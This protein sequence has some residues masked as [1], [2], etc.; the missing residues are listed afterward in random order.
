MAEI[1]TGDTKNGLG[2]AIL[3]SQKSDPTNMTLIFAYSLIAII[4]VLLIQLLSKYLRKVIN[5]IW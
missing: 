3:Y 2:S 4:F 1:L 5:G